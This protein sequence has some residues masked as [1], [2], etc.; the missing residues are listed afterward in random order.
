M[1]AFLVREDQAAT[2]GDFIVRPRRVLQTSQLQDFVVLVVLVLHEDEGEE[3]FITTLS[4]IAPW[5]L[6]AHVSWSVL[7]G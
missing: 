4:S 2:L 1:E 6:L 7:I 3:W 5:C